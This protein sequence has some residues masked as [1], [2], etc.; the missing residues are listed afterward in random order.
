MTMYHKNNIDHTNAVPN[1]IK[2][3]SN[4]DAIF[5]H[6]VNQKTSSSYESFPKLSVEFFSYG[7]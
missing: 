3:G 7:H 1:N 6:D 5:W 4:Y 2:K